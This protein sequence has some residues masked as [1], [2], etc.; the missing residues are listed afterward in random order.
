MSIVGPVVFKLMLDIIFSLRYQELI[1]PVM[2]VEYSKI[3]IY[4]GE[5]VSGGTG[6]IRGVHTILHNC[7]F[8][9]PYFMQ[10]MHDVFSSASDDDFVK[11]VSTTKTS[12]NLGFLPNMDVESYFDNIEEN[13]NSKLKSNKWAK[14]V[15]DGKAFI[16]VLSV[17]QYEQGVAGSKDFTGYSL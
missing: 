8:L 2:H 9:P 14:A 13:Y 3:T 6:F 10:I 4:I 1:S 15:D 12:Q 11:Y 17:Q 7:D 5:G 16:F